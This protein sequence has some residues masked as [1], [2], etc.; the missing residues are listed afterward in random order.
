MGPCIRHHD[1]NGSRRSQGNL[2]LFEGDGSCVSRYAGSGQCRIAGGLLR[3]DRQ[4]TRALLRARGA[5]AFLGSQLRTLCAWPSYVEYNEVR[6]QNNPPFPLHDDNDHR[7][8]V[9]VL[10]RKRSSR[11]AERSTVLPVPTEKQDASNGRNEQ[12]WDDPRST[13]LGLQLGDEL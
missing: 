12:G 11:G 3:I 10:N 5:I 4:A 8:F 9:A 1:Q 7:C 6:R 2:A 13:S